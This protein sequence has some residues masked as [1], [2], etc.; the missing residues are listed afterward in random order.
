MQRPVRQYQT[1][2]SEWCLLLSTKQRQPLANEHVTCAQRIGRPWGSNQVQVYKC[3]HGYGVQK[4]KEK[5]IWITLNFKND[6]SFVL[7]NKDV[8]TFYSELCMRVQYYTS[9]THYHGRSVL[10]MV[11]VWINT[12]IHPVFVKYILHSRENC[13]GQFK[14]HSVWQCL[15]PFNETLSW[16]T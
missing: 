1:L 9:F 8:C 12:I 6:F 4:K 11:L 15:V 13:L 7:C 3:T 16:C 2:E 10:R 5:K 14:P